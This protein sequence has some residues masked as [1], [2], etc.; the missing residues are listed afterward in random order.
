L[1]GWRA[2]LA[3]LLILATVGLLVY[4]SRILPAGPDG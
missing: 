2:G 3:A 1:F 4:Y